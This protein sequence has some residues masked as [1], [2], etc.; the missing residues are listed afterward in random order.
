MKAE[1][2]RKAGFDLVR[3]KMFRSEGRAFSTGCMTS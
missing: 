1:Q 2:G 3:K